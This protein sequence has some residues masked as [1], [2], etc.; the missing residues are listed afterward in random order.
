M[1]PAPM[2]EQDPGEAAANDTASI[3][4]LYTTTGN[5]LACRCNNN[6]KRTPRA[7]TRHIIEAFTQELVRQYAKQGEPQP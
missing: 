3:H 6:I 4:R 1:P 7:A 2:A 5:L